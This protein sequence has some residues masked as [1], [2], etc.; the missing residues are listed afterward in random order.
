MGCKVRN[1][2]DLRPGA[3]GGSMRAGVCLNWRAA[4]SWVTVSNR[5]LEDRLSSLEGPFSNFLN[6][7]S[8]QNVKADLPWVCEGL[9]EAV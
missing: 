9:A 5:L 2:L 8:K 6:A 7:L 1:G 4:R 3:L